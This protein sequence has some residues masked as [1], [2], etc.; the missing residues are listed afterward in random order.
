MAKLMWKQLANQYEPHEKRGDGL[1]HNFK[2][3]RAKVPGGWLI[4]GG[5][6]QDYGGGVTFMPDPE[7]AW[8]V[9]EMKDLRAQ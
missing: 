3:W 6:P 8:D 2:V 5:D 9:E 4:S 1:P 7:H